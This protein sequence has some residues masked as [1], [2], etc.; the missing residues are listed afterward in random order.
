MCAW[1]NVLAASADSKLNSPAM[2]AA[3]TTVASF[4]AL[5]PGVTPPP[6][7][8]IASRQAA[9]A[10]NDVPPPTVPTSMLGIVQH[11]HKSPLTSSSIR[12]MQLDDSTFCAGSCPVAKKTAVTILEAC[13]LNPPIAPAMADPI[14]FL[15]RFVCTRAETVVFRVVRTTSLGMTH[16]TTTDLPRPYNQ[17]VAAAFLSVHMFPERATN[18]HVGKYFWSV[19]MTA[20]DPLETMFIPMAS[21]EKHTNRR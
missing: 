12:V 9:C 19:S 5:A 11:I 13:A 17:F 8:P 16:S 6:L 4:L 15:L 18:W 7:H 10:G 2:V 3:A 21:P 20:S 1:T 14:R